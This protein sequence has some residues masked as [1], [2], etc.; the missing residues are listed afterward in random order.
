ME[1]NIQRKWVEQQ[2]GISSQRPWV[3]ISLNYGLVLLLQQIQNEAFKTKT[4]L[5]SLASQCWCFLSVITTIF[6]KEYSTGWNSFVIVSSLFLKFSNCC[7]FLKNSAFNAYRMRPSEKEENLIF[8]LVNFHLSP[9]ISRSCYI[10]V[11]NLTQI[12]QLRQITADY[13]TIVTAADHSLQSQ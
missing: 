12:Q 8:H 13:T 7:G 3:E 6:F 11:S 1:V 9:S 10:A 2:N 4:L 5:L